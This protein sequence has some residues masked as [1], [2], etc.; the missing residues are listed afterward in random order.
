MS[1]S[2]MNVVNV[3]ARIN[4]SVIRVYACFRLTFAVAKFVNEKQ[5]GKKNRFGVR[6][7]SFVAFR[8]C[9]MHCH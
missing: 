4:D 5:F 7:Y 3:R 1:Q 8:E 2:R 9:P 6:A